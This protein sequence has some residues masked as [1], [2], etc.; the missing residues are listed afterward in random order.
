MIES[1]PY[2]PF[3]PKH[4]TVLILG[5]FPPRRTYIDKEGNQILSF[6]YQSKRNQLWKILE[7][8]YGARLY[9]RIEDESIEENVERKKEF[10]AEHNIAIADIIKICR[11]KRPGSALDVDMEVLKLQPIDQLLRD[12]PSL[13]AVLCTSAY[14]YDL[15]RKNFGDIG[16]DLIKLPSPSPRHIL[17]FDEK[18]RRYKEILETYSERPR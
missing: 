14:V 15:M 7:A 17:P 4:A 3:I 12:N 16:A 5:S 11:R 1:H 8:I 9:H 6:F 18:A 13:Q 2:P 10:L